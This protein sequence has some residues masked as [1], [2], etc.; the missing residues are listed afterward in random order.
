MKTFLK[1]IYQES[2]KHPHFQLFFLLK[3][4]SREHYILMKLLNQHNFDN[5]LYAPY[6]ISL[7]MG[8][9]ELDGS[10]SYR[11][12]LAR[13]LL[14]LRSCNIGRKVCHDV[15][16]DAK[17]TVPYQVAQILHRNPDALAIPLGEQAPLFEENGIENKSFGYYQS[18]EVYQGL[19][20]ELH[21]LG[22]VGLSVGSDQGL[23]FYTMA[24]LSEVYNVDI[25]P[26]THIVT[27]LYL[28]AGA[29][30]HKLL[31]RY[32][33]VDEY[34]ALFQNENWSVTFSMLS[35]SSS[36]YTFPK[37][38]L[39]WMQDYYY[40]GNHLDSMSQYLKVKKEFYGRDSWIGTDN[41]LRHTIEGYEH[42]KIH[43][44]RG[45]I[46]GGI[47]LAIARRIRQQGQRVSLIYISNAPVGDRQSISIFRKLPIDESTRIVFSSRVHGNNYDD[48][49]GV[50]I[51]KSFIGILDWAIGV[52][53]P[54]ELDEWPNIH[55]FRHKREMISPGCYRFTK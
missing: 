5:V 23:D 2:P 6:N 42:G 37:R 3:T 21:G 1:S 22:G 55:D 45:D 43:V 7:F 24:S 26:Y 10:L 14:L 29:R 17:K 39:D 36:R 4:P 11:H 20:T 47:L 49:I 51:P 38:K 19:A 40:V 32:P 8:N 44:N 52:F 18:N 35:A 50:P 16:A 48:A 30:L 9:R 53:S 54:T 28:E 13:Q 46:T 25:D 41:A 31:G 33:T 15:L 27:S 12:D 34:I